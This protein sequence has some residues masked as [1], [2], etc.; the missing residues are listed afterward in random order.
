ML[1]L[2]VPIPYKERNQLDFFHTSMWWLKRFYEGLEGLVKPFEAP[3]KRVKVK[4]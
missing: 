3:Q 2:P 4:I 1:I